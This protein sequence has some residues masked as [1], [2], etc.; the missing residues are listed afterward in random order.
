MRSIG[1]TIRADGIGGDRPTSSGARRRITATA[2]IRAGTEPDRGRAARRRG[3]ANAGPWCASRHR[4][5]ILAAPPQLPHAVVDRVPQFADPRLS[6]SDFAASAAPLPLHAD[7]LRLCPRG[8]AGPWSGEG[9]LACHQA[10]FTLPSGPLSGR[11]LR[12]RSGAAPDLTGSSRKTG[13]AQVCSPSPLMGICD[14][15][16]RFA[17]V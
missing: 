10:H 6:N 15:N 11:K 9:Q 14:G 17:S 3:S 8:L 16:E 7:L 12:L 4:P 2:G 13:G 5:G 1:C